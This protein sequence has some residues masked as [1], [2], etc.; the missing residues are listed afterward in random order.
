MNSRI[1]LTARAV[2][3]LTMVFGLSVRLADAVEC[4]QTVSD[5]TPMTPGNCFT[6][7]Q[8]TLFDARPGDVVGVTVA[9]VDSLAQTALHWELYD[10]ADNLLTLAGGGTSC[11]AATTCY[12]GPLP[13]SDGPFLLCVYD[14]DNSFVDFN[15]ALE[16]VSATFNGASNGPPDPV[17]GAS[18]D[19]TEPIS[20]G[21]P[22]SG[23]INPFGDTD[24]FTFAGTAGSKV[25]V[26]LRSGD[27]TD[28]VFFAGWNLLAPNGSLIHLTGEVC[29]S[30]TC[31]QG[32]CESLPLPQSGIYTI[33]VFDFVSGINGSD[34]VGTGY[35]SL[36]LS[37]CGNGVVEGN[38][39]CDTGALNG[40]GTSCCLVDCTF[41]AASQVCR[42][43][44]PGG[45]D[46]ADTCTGTSGTC[47]EDRKEADKTACEDGNICT[48]ASTCQSGQCFPGDAVCDVGD[49]TSIPGAKPQLK[50]NC[51]SEGKKGSCKAA[52]LFDPTAAPQ[53][54]GTS[55]PDA[56]LPPAGTVLA[57]SKA[58][59]VKKGHGVTLVL[60][61]TKAGR[62][63]FQTLSPGES[64]TVKVQVAIRK[65]PVIG[66]AM[67]SKLSQLIR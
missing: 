35:Y 26:D 8:E 42:E 38:E 39:Q 13:S 47:P 44:A 46:I 43:A 21:Q 19:G 6:L 20:G 48:P 2:S 41:R 32:L 15:L 62:K 59:S 14:T 1:G 16:A 34:W 7:H 45:C 24:T 63:S 66:T 25:R 51:G 30:D 12:S 10:A 33:L 36:G 55:R 9:P 4:G 54:V 60:K 58:R 40:D 65:V 17:C 18:L 28:G 56:V 61:L 3:A 29:L 50:V 64:L 57:T 11:P 37:T 27:A 67:I 52:A 53:R 23:A 49:V 5:Q 31:C 22:V